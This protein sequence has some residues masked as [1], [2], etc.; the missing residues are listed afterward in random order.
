MKA[1]KQILAMLLLLI[2][3]QSS[4][5][6]WHVYKSD[7]TMDT[8]YYEEV[9]SIVPYGPTPTATGKAIDLG[10]PSGT[11]WASFN[12]GASSPEDY[13]EYYAWGETEVKSDYSINTY[14]YYDSE[15][16]TVKDLGNNIV[17]TQYDVAHVKWGGSWKMPTYEQCYELSHECTWN[18]TSINNVLGYNVVGPNGN[19]IYLPAGG[20]F[21]GSKIIYKGS[22]GY[23]WAGNPAYRLS[24][25]GPPDYLYYFGT[26][27]ATNDFDQQFGRNIRPVSM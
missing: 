25:Y 26:Q 5:Q 22:Q 11:K 13:G 16:H 1:A 19:S 7:G 23:Y 4:A 17:G 10:L 8:Y 14:L 6:G 18:L 24:Y 9:D 12:L 15:N 20:Y 2:A 21:N 3:T 27:P